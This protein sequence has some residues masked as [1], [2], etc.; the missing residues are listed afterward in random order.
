MPRDLRCGRV[1]D[2]PA[3]R[4]SSLHSVVLV[5]TTRSC[6][7]LKTKLYSKY[8][9]SREPSTKKP[10]RIRPGCN[11]E[12]DKHCRVYVCSSHDTEPESSNSSSFGGAKV[13]AA[14]SSKWKVNHNKG[15]M[16][17]CIPLYNHMHSVV[18]CDFLVLHGHGPS[19]ST[20]RQEDAARDRPFALDCSGFG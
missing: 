17:A 4:R 13:T 8:L 6:S 7:A 15:P 20:L 18:A 9:K 12:A 1:R 11:L 10:P 19:G 16:D 2:L 14:R 3:K 5:T